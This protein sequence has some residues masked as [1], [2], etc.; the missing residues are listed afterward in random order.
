[1]SNLPAKV[2]VSSF[3]RS[4]NMEGVPKCQKVGHVTPSRSLLT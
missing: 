2:K 4:R 3:S 1:M